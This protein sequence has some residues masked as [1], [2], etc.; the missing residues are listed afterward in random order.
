MRGLMLLPLL[1][2]T[3]LA[4]QV[5]AWF[6]R[7]VVLPTDIT[8]VEIREGIDYKAR[9]ALHIG[10]DVY[11]PKTA[12]PVPAVILVHG[13]PTAS[14][15]VEART[16][17][18]LRS[19]G[20]ILASHGLAAITFTHRLTNANAVDTAAAD[21]RDATAYVV[22]HAQTLGVDPAR[23]C[24][25]A[26]SAGG[27]LIGPTV[28]EFADRIRCLV[29]YYTVLSPALL[30]DLVGA[31]ERLPQSTPSLSEL[32]SRDSL[33]LPPTL[34]IRAGKDDPRLNAGI[35]AFVTLAIQKGTE[36]ELHAYPSG[37]HAFDIFDDTETSR[38]LLLQTVGFLKTHLLGN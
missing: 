21:I 35:D 14:L 30:Q 11:R 16:S 34:L 4:A 37:Q 19:L 36:L 32:M 6:N 5:P 28:R 25:W 15:P 1:L 7:P 10:L 33:H 18:Q 9:P 27:S 12:S 20:R 17:G 31:G 23:L 3:R 38:R 8:Q 29:A 22:S 13:G 26:I 24:V 2:A